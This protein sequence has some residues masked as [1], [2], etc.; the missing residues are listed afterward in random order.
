MISRHDWRCTT[1]AAEI[2]PAM[3]ENNQKNVRFLGKI[4]IYYQ[5]SYWA[6]FIMLLLRAEHPTTQHSNANNG[7]FLT[8][9]RWHYYSVCL[10]M[11]QCSVVFAH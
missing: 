7:L 10:M 11:M 4:I 5:I 8:F 1:A 9:I 2:K 6:N 3:K